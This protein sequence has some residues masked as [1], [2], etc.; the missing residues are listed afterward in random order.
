[1]AV[2]QSD[3]SV[4]NTNTLIANTSAMRNPHCTIRLATQ[5]ECFDI[6]GQGCARARTHSSIDNL[7][8][9]AEHR[10]CQAVGNRTC[11][12]LPSKFWETILDRESVSVGMSIE[13][14]NT[15]VMAMKSSNLES[16]FTNGG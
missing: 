1:M 10:S 13:D 11:N 5:F 14:I 6:P 8:R 3:L 2:G 12:W 15:N 16:S 4:A 9:R 7:R